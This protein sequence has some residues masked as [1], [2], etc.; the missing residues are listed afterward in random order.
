MECFRCD[1]E[2]TAECPRC[3]ALY[4]DDHGDALCER[5]Q[6]PALALPSYRVYRG[7]LLALLGGTAFAV[8]LLVR[9]PV[10]T[11]GDS[12]VPPALAGVIPAVTATA[13]PSTATPTPTAS[14][15]AT[16]APSPTPDATAAPPRP[17]FREHTVADGDTLFSIAL[18]YLP[19]NKE[20]LT[21]VEEIAAFNDLTDAN[22]ITL[23][24]M[25][26]IPL[27]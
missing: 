23:G 2:A 12:P 4:C 27:E 8:W 16:P 17:D 22:A 18:Q 5:C 7:S 14:P 20:V 6:D 19:R 13:A 9:P 26:K 10:T 24:T 1:R 3:G 15:T 11:D 25:L 21:F